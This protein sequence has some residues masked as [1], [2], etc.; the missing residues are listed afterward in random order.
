MVCEVGCRFI[1][2][3]RA[4]LA[5]INAFEVNGDHDQTVK[6]AV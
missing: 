5:I 1:L 3:Q 6:H 2:T 4:T